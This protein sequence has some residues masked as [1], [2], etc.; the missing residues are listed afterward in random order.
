M[1]KWL[2]EASSEI[3]PPSEGSRSRAASTRLIQ[4]PRAFTSESTACET[5][6]PSR[7]TNLGEEGQAEASSVQ[8]D[9]LLQVIKPLLQL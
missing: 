8:L 1:A 9:L 3:T 5:A 7:D 6:S 2:R 4:L